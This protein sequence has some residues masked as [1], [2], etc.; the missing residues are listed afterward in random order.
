MATNQSSDNLRKTINADGFDVQGGTT[1]RK[2]TISGADIGVVGS[3]T[4]VHTFP[5]YSGT[6]DEHKRTTV[7]DLAYTVLTT[8]RL[9][10]YTSLTAARTVT[11]PA[12]STMSSR[13]ITIKDEAGTAGTNNITVDANGAETID[14]QLTKLIHTNYGTLTLYCNGTSW[15]VRDI[16]QGQFIKRTLLTSGTSFTTT[17]NTNKIILRL[18]AGGGGG[19][20]TTTAAASAALGGGGSAG[21]YAEKTFNVDPNTAYT[22]AIGAAGAAGNTSGGNGG[23]GG[24]TTFAVG[25]T[26]VTANGGL[27]GIGETAGTALAVIL[28][29]ASPAV[30]TNGDMNGGGAPG[31]VGI[32]LSGLLGGSGAG[33]SCLFGAG[34]NGLNAAGAGVVGVGYGAGGSGGC[35]LNN[36]AAVAGGAGLAGCIV[37]EEYS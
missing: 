15:F 31:A 3:G 37:V 2:L 25:A 33:G 4:N 12:A 30:S 6:V 26:T 34:G 29:G 22:Y 36:S 11:L 28:G 17:V 19:G 8:D 16:T 5:G 14:G 35:V 27:G 10:A 9:I 13:L 20:G 32:R 18:Q 7:A 1:L 21:G 24:V 23:V